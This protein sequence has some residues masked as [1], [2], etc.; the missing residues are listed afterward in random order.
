MSL[1]RWVQEKLIIHGFNPGLV[2]GVWGRSTIGALIA[3]QLNKGLPADGI[4]N[5]SA[6]DKLGDHPRGGGADSQPP[7]IEHHDHFPWMVLAMR[8]V[9]LHE[10]TNN[11][12]LQSF[13]KSD[14]STLG[15][16]SKAP[17]CGDFV[18]T[19]IAVT[20]PTAALPGNPYLA[21][22]WLKFGHTVDP[23]YGS[24]LVFWREARA[25]NKGHVG[26]YHAEDDDAYHV[27]GGN[28]KNSIGISRVKKERLLGARLPL[29]GGPFPRILSKWA[30]NGELSI[31]EA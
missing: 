28:Q 27:L 17:W 30:A 7:A 12:E 11:V 25:G 16:P 2:D 15:D 24:I 13:L 4:L 29:V 31:D 21:R 26:F 3:F 8:K 23:C 5:R 10:Q 14:G 22:N 18:E 6:L 20:L 1:V 19:C 9:G